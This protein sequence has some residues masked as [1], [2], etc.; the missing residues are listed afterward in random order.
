MQQARDVERIPDLAM[1]T[2]PTLVAVVFTSIDVAVLN[3]FA[4]PKSVTTA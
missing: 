2:V 1:I 4:T 3:A